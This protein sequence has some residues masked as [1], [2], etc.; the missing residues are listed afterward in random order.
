M[1]QNSK[2]SDALPYTLLSVKLFYSVYY[3][4]VPF[5][6]GLQCC[7]FYLPRLIWKAI[8]LNRVGIDLENLIEQSVNAQ[9]VQGEARKEAIENIASDIEDILFQ[10]SL[11]GKYSY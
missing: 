5:V 8:S 10:V 1:V 3:Q 4:W 7:L 9:H 2:F 6:L 11:N